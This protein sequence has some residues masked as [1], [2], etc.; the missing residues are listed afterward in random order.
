MQALSVGALSNLSMA[1]LGDGTIREQD[2]PKVI[3]AINNTMN[4]LHTRF[5][6]SLGELRLRKIQGLREYRLRPEHADS[7]ADAAPKF[8][9]DTAEDPFLD[10]VAAI[11]EVINSDGSPLWATS[12]RNTRDLRI[13][14]NRTIILAHSRVVTGNE[15]G[16]TYR[17][18]FAPLELRAGQDDFDLGLPVELL[19]ALYAG[20]A[21]QIFSNMTGQEHLA[22]AQEQTMLFETL[23]GEVTLADPLRMTP[24]EECSKFHARGWV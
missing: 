21:S 6:L 4:R 23:V 5:D 16:V 17:R 1:Q 19:P 20:V 7:T 3:L 12:T 8:I 15:W 24:D 18:K 9:I 22:K 10:D 13:E 11:R 14:D 2:Q